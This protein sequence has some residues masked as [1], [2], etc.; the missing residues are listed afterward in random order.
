M[1]RASVSSRLGKAALLHEAPPLCSLI[2]SVWDGNL[3]PVPSV[4]SCSVP[5]ATQT[6]AEHMLALPGLPGDRRFRAA[7]TQ[8][9]SWRHEPGVQLPLRPDLL[10]GARS[11]QEPRQRGTITGW[12]P[13]DT[14]RFSPALGRLLCQLIAFTRLKVKPGSLGGAGRELAA[15]HGLCPGSEKADGA[16]GRA[17]GTGGFHGTTRRV[18][19]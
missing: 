12:S 5:R 16:G 7:G 13:V 8:T 14:A 15:A 10:R 3:E 1:V 9:R 18:R 2:V 19:G 11:L 17:W 6:P 4:S